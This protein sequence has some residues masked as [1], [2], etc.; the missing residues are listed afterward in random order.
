[1]IRNILNIA[2]ND[3]RIFF[4]N[5]GNI[6]GLVLLPVAFTLVLGFAFS[7]GGPTVLRVDVIDQDQSDAS[8]QLIAEVRAS[9]D[10]LVICPDDGTAENCPETV[11]VDTSRER[12]INGQVQSAIV[13]PDGFD[14]SL[15]D[16]QPVTL[17]Y[18]SQQDVRSGDPVYQA[19][20]SVVQRM[21]AAIQVATVGLN[22]TDSMIVTDDGTVP[23]FESD[24]AREA[25]QQDVYTRAA[26]QIADSPVSVQ[27]IMGET[28]SDQVGLGSGFG[29][30]VPG[31]G[32]MYVMFTVFGGL[33]LLARER[34]QWTLQRLMAMPLT[35]AEIM[36]GK[37]L[38]YFTLGMIQYTVV[39]AVG[40]IVGAPLGDSPLALVM[41]MVAFVTCMVAL[42]FLLATRITNESQASGITLLLALTLAP[43]GGAWWPLEITPDFMQAL[44]RL[45]PV[46]WAMEGFQNVI[47][48]SGGVTDVLPS[49]VVLLGIAL[50]LFVIGVRG[51]RYDI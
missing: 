34:D 36:G 9:Y 27:L 24:E 44:G 23:L 32:S 19:L 26:E 15:A 13:I 33:A 21:S 12:V 35:R 40:I 17:E 22:V 39:F 10:A 28:S 31:M 5:R 45:S 49:V 47:F 2:L 48:F 42:T 41:V 4:S 50:V 20:S 11:D 38:A 18:Y 43:L 30:S 37:M 29:Q 6:I 25:F 14:E 1:M 51:F 8:Q 16:L 7:G 46:S 3:L